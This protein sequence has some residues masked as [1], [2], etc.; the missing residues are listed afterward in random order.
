M[1][2]VL[3]LLLCAGIVALVAFAT[4]ARVAAAPP[5]YPDI[6]PIDA[7]HP[8]M[9][10]YGLTVFHGTKIERFEVTVVGVVRKGSWTVP[11]H[12]MILVK[13]SG[14]PIT[15]RGA[16]K[17]QGMSGSPIYIGGRII[18][19]FSQAES[20]LKEPLGGVTPIEDMLEAW[21]P[22]LP[23]KPETA[24][25]GRPCVISLARPLAIDGRSIR[26]IVTNAP[27]VEFARSFGDTLVL[28]RCATTVTLATRSAAARDKLR[29]ALAPYGVE[30]AQT[31]A[32]NQSPSFKGAPLVPGAAFSMMLSTGDFSSGA[33]GTITYRRGDRILGFGH[34]FMGI[35][36]IEAPLCSAYIHDVYPLMTASYKIGTPG[37]IAGA[38]VQDRNFSISGV[39][40]RAPKLIDVSVDVQ[41]RSNG[42]SHVYHSQVVQHPNLSSALVSVAVSAAVEDLRGIPGAAYAR[43]TTSI[44][45]EGLGTITRSNTVFDTRGIDGV[46]TTDLDDILAALSRNPFSIVP[47]RNVAVKVRISEGRPTATIERIFLRQGKLEPGRQAEIGI[48]LKPY[49]KPAVTRTVKLTVPSNTPPGAYLV[50]VRGGA[51][52][53]GISLGGI[54]IRPAQPASEQAPP[55]SVRQMVDRLLERERGNEVV[56]RLLLPTTAPTVDGDRLSGLP[57]TLDTVMRSPHS[58]GVQLERNEVK[59]VEPTEWIVAGAQ[60][61]SINV[62]RHDSRET[63]PPPSSSPSTPAPAS[64][65]SSSAY[66]SA[67][68][69]LST[70]TGRVPAALDA[71]IGPRDAARTP[72][73]RAAASA[74]PSASK[75]ESDEESPATPAP[76]TSATEPQVGR[77]A[78]TW[79]QTAR[80]DFARGTMTRARVSSAG[81]LTPTRSVTQLF[82]AT[83]P[84]V[85]CLAPDG[86]DGIYAGVGTRARIL[87]IDASGK[88]SV[89]CELPEVSVHALLRDPDGTLWAATGPNG[90][91]YRIPPGGKPEVAFQAAEKYA[92]CL[93]RD[94]SGHTAV[95]VGGGRGRVYRLNAGSG[96]TVA[97]DTADEHVLAVA[98]GPGD[99][100][101]AGTAPSGIIMRLRPGGAPETLVD[102]GYQS[103]TALAPLP[104]GAVLA[105]TATKAALIRVAP[106][107]TTRTLFE[108]SGPAFTSLCPAADG[109]VYAAAGSSIYA[110]RGDTVTELDNAVDVDVLSL[111]SLP[112]GALYAGTGNAG[113]VLVSPA[114]AGVME[115]VYESVAHDAGVPARWGHLRITATIPSGASIVA[116]TRSGSSAEPDSTWSP[117]T[118]IGSADGRIASPD[119]RYVQYR[120]RLAGQAG[121]L[122]AVREVSVSYLPANQP[123]T[124]AFQTPAGGEWWSG[125]QTVRW[126][127]SDPDKDTLAYELFAAPAEGGPW[128]PLAAAA[129]PEPPPASSRPATSSDEA[130]PRKTPAKA[131]PQTVADVQT[132]LDAHPDLPAGLRQ[133]ILERAKRLNAE[134]EASRPSSSASAETPAPTRETSRTI[135]T[136]VLPDGAYRLKVVASDR[137]SNAVDPRQAEAI[138][139]RIVI[140]NRLPLLLVSP[141]R[142][143]PDRKVELTGIALHRSA[144]I[145]G[146]QVRIDGG[147]WLAA[148]PVDGLFDTSLESFSVRTDVLPQG[149]HSIEVTAFAASGVSATETVSVEVK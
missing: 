30:V 62:Q 28:H 94:A 89:L 4:P 40:G 98:F 144:P 134:K 86:A 95:G 145:T 11:G 80:T 126:T 35:G 109:T 29:A 107:G 19:A 149:A 70:Q 59:V 117:W 128:R 1:F 7:V 5:R 77:K 88:S 26:R 91:V 67:D 71:R 34:P 101:Y 20:M 3:R 116:E 112:S 143:L 56:V 43:V 108:R 54:T 12:D 36:P 115:G 84:Y 38:S 110:V 39:V 129:A 58:S 147:P 49:Q 27:N 15:E 121:A 136:S 90:R 103:I 46:V 142:V 42:R 18:G 16:Y 68:L 8:G 31:G 48:V 83:D 41:D 125:K 123:P 131:S 127:A 76:A 24:I 14:G 63:A 138:S 44:D 60:A 146:V 33:I 73:G 137:P 21:D 96:A 6:M 130:R 140:A 22:A 124:V 75:E 78:Q 9:K 74:S 102:T 79:V 148:A 55:T 118:R 10:G 2:R 47:V 61:I 139:E 120:L 25:E 50:S 23:D 132:M 99:V 105:A 69:D 51:P 106:D 72:R 119:A 111:C 13:L 65:T 64:S 53:A 104:D 57:P 114:P 122:P 100:L 52:P 92:L 87:H 81:D 113:G 17:I 141:P 85:W 66:V 32:A 93:A 133:A 135:D 45:T 37:P 97:L 82:T